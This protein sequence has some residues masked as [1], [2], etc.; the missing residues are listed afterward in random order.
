MLFDTGI[1]LTLPLGLTE[2]KDLKAFFVGQNQHLVHELQKTAVSPKNQ[3]VYLWGGAGVGKSHLLQA[4]L[5]VVS[6]QGLS[7][8]YVPLKQLKHHSP[9][10]VLENLE[11]QDV[12]CIDDVDEVAGDAEW[13]E[14]LFHLFNRARIEQVGLI[15]SSQSAPMASPLTLLDLRSRLALSLVFQMNHL[16]DTAL[17]DALIFIAKQRATSLS[18]DVAKF[19]VLHVSRSAA[20]LFEL[21]EAVEI[22]ALQSGRRLT[23][24]FLKEF[25]L[26]YQGQNLAKQEQE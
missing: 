21:L 24:P 9:P 16:D 25:L 10:E 17:V 7:G 1:Q 8:F 12:L 20:V 18:L 26:Y 23:I 5:A 19:M 11:Y 3:L 14:A 2:K 13:Q 4:T 15:F 22:A 6:E